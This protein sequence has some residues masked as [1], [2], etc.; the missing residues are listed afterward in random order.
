M[1]V[2]KPGFVTQQIA[3]EARAY[4]VLLVMSK[5]CSTNATESFRTITLVFSLAIEALYRRFYLFVIRRVIFLCVF[6]LVFVLILSYWPIKN[7]RH[8]VVATKFRMR[9]SRTGSVLECVVLPSFW[10]NLRDWLFLH[11]TVP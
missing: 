5:C 7:Y 10:T 4:Y 1:R 9:N 3:G 6:L 8:I 2:V 11:V